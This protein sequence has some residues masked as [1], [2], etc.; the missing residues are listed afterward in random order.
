MLLG[1]FLSLNRQAKGIVLEQ[2]Q[3]IARDAILH[4]QVRYLSKKLLGKIERQPC[5]EWYF[6]NNV[7][8]SH[9]ASSNIWNSDL[10]SFF[11]TP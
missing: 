1:H 9:T 6:S 3:K 2:R 7:Q 4:L 5:I 8:L 10:Q 11:L